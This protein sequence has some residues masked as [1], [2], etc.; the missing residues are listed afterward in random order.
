[1]LMRHT[2][3]FMHIGI[4]CRL[5][6]Y[7]MGGIS[8]YTIQLIQAL[9]QVAGAEK[10][11]IFHKKGEKRSFLPDDDT[12]FSRSDLL[13]PCHHRLERR[14]L[15]VELARHRLDVF[16][17]PDFIPPAPATA[18]RVITVHDLSF[19]YF[20]EI[21][22]AE[23]RRYY[24]DQIG[25]AV[26]VADH[27]IADS[28]A[29]RD[30]VIK[31]LGVAPGRITTIHLAADEVFSAGYDVAE[32]GRTVAEYG[33]DEGYI[34]FV[35]TLEPRK[36]LGML[37]RAYHRLR[38]ERGVKVPLVLVG[39]K[40]WLYEEIFDEIVSLGLGDSVRHLSDV[41]DVKLAHLYRAAGV[42]AF[43]S[44]YEGFG[45]PALEAM[46]GGCPVVCAGRGSLP[47]VV[48]SAAIQLDPDDVD[49]W[50]AAIESVLGDSVLA[51][52]MRAEGLAQAQKFSWLKTAEATMAVYRDEKE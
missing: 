9:S 52:R 37:L 22:T 18:R 46:L 34:L 35:G 33:I 24:A 28:Y 6:S 47:E 11:T 27:I 15:A 14:A 50:V 39:S 12:R 17:S 23:S 29:T 21:L 44:Y 38:Q 1:M 43:P 19:L 31:L 10:F 8:R 51:D 42:L 41:S 30:D 49:G 48:G 7:R 16:H 4:D 40:G 3:P 36:N 25:W 45:L 5:P 26:N 13:T 32:I 2:I 20:P